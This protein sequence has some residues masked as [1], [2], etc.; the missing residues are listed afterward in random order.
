V[1]GQATIATEAHEPQPFVPENA[2]QS[3]GNEKFVFRAKE[4]GQYQKQTVELG[5]K[6]AG[7][8]LVQSGV[9]AGDKIVGKG[10]FTLKAEMLKSQFS[11]EE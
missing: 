10:S 4:K 7:G 8:Y 9:Q 3:Y 2:V 6:V 11:E 5:S 1:L